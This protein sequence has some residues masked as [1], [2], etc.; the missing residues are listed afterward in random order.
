[1][2]GDRFATMHLPPLRVPFEGLVWFRLNVVFVVALA[3]THWR[4]DILVFAALLVPLLAAM[5]L[6]VGGAWRGEISQRDVAVVWVPTVGTFPPAL[7][8][9]L[10][11]PAVAPTWVL[12]LNLPWLVFEQHRTGGFSAREWRWHPV[13]VS[14]A[15]GGCAGLLMGVVGG[16]RLLLPRIVVA[17][18]F[19]A[20]FCIVAQ[21]WTG[22]RWVGGIT[23]AYVLGQTGDDQEPGVTPG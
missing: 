19:A 8:I 1:M 7:G 4:S 2:M 13:V 17:A 3:A 14:M 6:S 10:F 23:G 21:R 16:G 18:V 9:A 20:S 22:R 5:S 15:M 11:H 12:A